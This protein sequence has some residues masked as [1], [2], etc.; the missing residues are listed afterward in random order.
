MHAWLCP[1]CFSPF[2]D[3]QTRR[4]PTCQRDPRLE[5]RWVLPAPGTEPA[6]PDALHVWDAVTRRLRPM[7]EAGLRQAILPDARPRLLTLLAARTHRL[8]ALED[9][10]ARFVALIAAHRAG[11]PAPS[12]PAEPEVSPRLRQALHEP[13]PALGSRPAPAPP[14]RS[15]GPDTA[16]QAS[17]GKRRRKR[18]GQGQSGAPGPAT[19]PPGAGAS[20]ASRRKRAR[21][22]QRA[23]LVAGGLVLALTT[24]GAIL[25][26]LM[27]A[28]PGKVVAEGPDLPAVGKPGAERFDRRRGIPSPAR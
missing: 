3:G 19:A 7:A 15:A 1:H 26:V 22:K 12:P 23:S 16:A 14:P 28:G 25:F 8:A 9:P 27:P 24:L 4:C 20:T 6:R 13:P 5:H 21:G 2:E 17:G 10:R 18:S 11:T